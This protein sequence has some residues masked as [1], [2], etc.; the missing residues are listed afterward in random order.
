MLRIL[1]VPALAASFVSLSL[2]A[3]LM[4]SFTDVPSGWSVDRYAPAGFSSPSSPQFGVGSD[5]EISIGS[6][7]G[8][9]NRPAPD[10]LTYYDYQGEATAVSGGVGDWLAAQL[11]IP[12]SWATPSDGSVSTL[13]WAQLGGGNDYGIVGFTNYSQTNPGDVGFVVWNDV[14]S[15]FE[16]LNA[17][18]DYNGWNSLEIGLV[19]GVSG[20]D[21]EYLVNNS[22]AATVPLRNDSTTFTGATMDAINYF[23]DPT[24]TGAVP[25]DYTAI[26]ANVSGTP[27][28]STQV[29]PEPATW[30]LITG[31][32]LGIALLRRVRG[33]AVAAAKLP[34]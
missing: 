10:Q 33:P 3:N 21:L 32:I 28:S 16:A 27:V 6:D 9:D 13:M 23:G 8:W 26:W 4:P 19:N 25:V 29:T 5:L 2:A 20:T 22:L 11:Y 31:G 18:I 1:V 17:P 12:A 34:E 7:Q 30:L 14:T 24:T 15:S